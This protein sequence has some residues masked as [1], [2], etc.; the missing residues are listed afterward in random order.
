[1]T[2]GVRGLVFDP[3]RGVLLVRHTYLQGWYLPGGG[4]EPGETL[5]EAVV[6][7]IDEEGSVLV[8]A[9]PRLCGIYLNRH[10]SPRDHV[11]LF[12][13]QAFH[14]RTPLRPPDGEIAEA[15]FFPLEALPP[16]TTPATHRRIAETLH[17]APVPDVW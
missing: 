12:H 9:P 15:R 17:G 10:V 6:R 4:V 8:D 3:A 13:V 2:L 16:D 5:L 14:M 11:A 1:M 7:E